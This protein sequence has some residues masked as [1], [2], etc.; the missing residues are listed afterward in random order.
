MVLYYYYRN[1]VKQDLLTKFCYNNVAQ[2]PGLK[3][4][5]LSFQVSQS[6]LRQLL[7]F[8]SSLTIVSMQKPYLLTSNRVNLVLK[9]RKGVPIGCKVSLHKK[10]IY[11]FLERLL[12]FVLPQYKGSSK[13][14]FRVGKKNIFFTLDNLFSFKE[15]EKEYENFQDLPKLHVSFVVNSKEKEE[16]LSLLT[17]LKFP[18]KNK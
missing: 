18:I 15:V 16:I 5:S 14:I 12:F 2:I 8:L 4:I 9:L 3:K 6:S 10:Q 7:P 11:A 1:I 13:P 17:A